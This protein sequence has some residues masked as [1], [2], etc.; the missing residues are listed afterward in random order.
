MNRAVFRRVLDAH[1]LCEEAGDPI[2]GQS[3]LR[4]RQRQF[5]AS[6]FDTRFMA[7]RRAK[8]TSAQ[9]RRMPA[10]DPIASMTPPPLSRMSARRIAPC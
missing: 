7:L 6:D 5:Q 9:V 8:I 3:A 2:T 10:V 4:M 1:E